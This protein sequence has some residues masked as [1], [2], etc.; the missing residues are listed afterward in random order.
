MRLTT[1][2]AFALV[3]L[4]LTADSALAQRGRYYRPPPPPPPREPYRPYESRPYERTAYPQPYQSGSSS[5]DDTSIEDEF[6]EA[7]QT[8]GIISFLYVVG[9]LVAGGITLYLAVKWL[10]TVA[11]K[12][13]RGTFLTL[14]FLGGSCLGTGWLAVHFLF[15]R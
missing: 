9:G 13:G 4:G 1:L 14:L 8:R 6:Q 7:E 5:D 11:S 12:W 15:G 10:E 2:F 3:L